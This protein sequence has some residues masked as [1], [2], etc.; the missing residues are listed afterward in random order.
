MGIDEHFF[1]RKNGYAT[2]ISD[3]KNHKVFD[4]VLGRSELSLRAY[5]VNRRPTPHC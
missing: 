2:T 5:L 1:S 3:L 4:V